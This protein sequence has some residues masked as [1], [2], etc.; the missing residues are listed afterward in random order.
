[1]AMNLGFCIFC[2]LWPSNSFT[3]LLVLLSPAWVGASMPMTVIGGYHP[4]P[5]SQRGVS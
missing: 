4:Y 3:Y 5:K 2:E 1:M